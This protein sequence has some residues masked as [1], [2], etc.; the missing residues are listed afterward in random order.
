ML[1]D[2][3]NFFLAIAV[4]GLAISGLSKPAYLSSANLLTFLF[5]NL[6]SKTQIHIK[7]LKK[8]EAKS[9]SRSQSRKEPQLRLSRLRVLMFNINR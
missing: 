9:V 5:V 3:R 8:S 4:S 6:R 1:A 2:W 7:I